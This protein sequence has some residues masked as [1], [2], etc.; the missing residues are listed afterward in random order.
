MLYKNDEQYTLTPADHKELKKKF[1]KFPIRLTYPESRIKKSKLKHNTLPDKPNSISFPLVAVVKTG[2]GA[3]NWRYAENKIVGTNGRTI[4]APHNLIL[5]GTMT[6]TETDIELVWWLVN[7]CPFLKGGKN[8][9]NKVPKCIIEDLVGQAEKKAIREEELATVKAL[10][11]SSKMGLG[12]KQL[13]MVAKAYFI[14]DVEELSYAQVKL[15]VENAISRDKRTGMEKFLELVN[16]EQVLTVRANLQQAIDNDIITY[17]VQKKMWAWVTAQGKKNIPIAHITGG[18]DPNEALYDY[19]LGDRKFAQEIVAALK[20]EKVVL[21]EGAD[22]PDND[23]D[24]I[25]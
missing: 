14:T 8:F 20:G 25:D 18:T 15:A 12:E 21:P 22:N 11:Y 17:M 23:A 13:R 9:N 10:I 7:C 3:E 24:P 19:Y 2:T 16:S 4:W 1:P 6:L 5:R